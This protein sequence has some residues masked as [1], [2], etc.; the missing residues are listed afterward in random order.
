[1]F[2]VING[3]KANQDPV[4][5][6][7]SIICAGVVP[8]IGHNFVVLVRPLDPTKDE[9][10]LPKGHVEEGETTIVAAT[11]EAKEEAGAVVRILSPEAVSI[12]TFKTEK[13]LKETHWF[14]GRV[15]ALKTQLSEEPYGAGTHTRRHIGIF[16]ATV[17]LARLTF[18]DHREVLAQVL[19]GGE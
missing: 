11:R 18:E 12:T 17:A 7:P 10:L 3:G 2:N 4:E 13:G 14:V 1:M 9:W 16:P 6:P 19:G 5:L 15:A 8:I